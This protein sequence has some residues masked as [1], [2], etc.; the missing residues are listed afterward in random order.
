MRYDL[1]STLPERAFK[2]SLFK[3]APATL[4]GGGKGGG[5]PS[6]TQATSYQTNVPEYARP[7]VENMLNATQKQLFNTDDSG[8]TGFK[9]Y[10]P[11]SSNPSDYYAGFSPM[12]QQAQSSAANLQVPGQFGQA[13]DMATMS[14]MG[15]LG[16]AGQAGMYG[17]QGN[18][19]G[20]RAAGLSNMYGGAGA[21]AGQQAAGIS[22]MYGG[23]GAMSGQQYANQSAGAGQQGAD[24]GQQ[25]GGQSAMYGGMGAMQ[26]MQG[27][28][29]GQ[30]LGQMST[31]ANAQQ[32]Y[33]NPY[34]QNALNPQ[35]AEIQRQYDITGQGQQSAAAKSG[36]FG[37]SREALMAAENQR[38]KNMAM[39]QVIGQ[40]YNQAFT[41]AQQQMNAANQAALSG[42][43]QALQGYGMGL[44][45]VGQAG[46]L[47]MQ[48]TGQALQGYGQAG[49]QALAGY[50]MG[51]QGAGQAGQQAMQ[52]YG[53]GLQGAGQA[54]SQA[55]QGAGLGLQG[56]GA[57]QNAYNQLGAAGSNLANIGGQQLAAQQGIIGTQ[58]QQGATQQALEQSKINQ[59][60][61]DYA[62]AQQYPMMQL[63]A[64]SNMLRGLPMQ[65]TAV[66]SYQAQ[67]PVAQQAAGLL[68]AYN[69]YTG[70]KE[71]G[72]IK[73]MAKGG[74][75][76]I[77][78]YKSGVLIGL[79][80]KI[81]DIAQSDTYAQE[82]QKQLPKLMQQTTSPGIKQLIA[83]KQAEDQLGQN[84][85]GVAA[86]NTGDLGMNMAEGGI[87][88]RFAT[89]TEVK[90]PYGLTTAAAEASKGYATPEE[91][92]TTQQGLLASGLKNVQAN[93]SPEEQ[94][95]QKYVQERRAGL[96]DK[97]RR[98]EK[99]NEALAFLK[100][101]STVG[102]LGT[103]ATEGAKSYMIGQGEIQKTYDELNDNLVKQA[104]EIKKAQR[105]EAK[106]DIDKAQTHFDKAAKYKLDAIKDNATLLNTLETHKMD[107]T[108]RERVA[109]INAAVHAAPTTFLKE[110]LQRYEKELTAE[111]A[112][113]GLPPPTLYDIQTR[114]TQATK[115][116]DETIAAADRRAAG[117]KFADFLTNIASDPGI[118]V[119]YMKASK[120]DKEAESLVKAY[121]DKKRTE[122]Y[123]AYQT[124]PPTAQN[125]PAAQNNSFVM[126]G[127]KFPDQKSLDAYKAAKAK[128]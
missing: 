17:A 22:N 50:G 87:I 83:T 105:A 54:G 59:S 93:L 89:G 85:S 77:P 39:N 35:L 88:P 3:N 76:D 57:Q 128:Q 40:G 47:G 109:Q 118:S 86:G 18:M 66:Q 82:G 71:G 101:G 34:L 21:Q 70:K 121:I 63:G 42:N 49:S 55:M 53:M 127:Y 31:N 107:N 56:V 29:I 72:E 123:N 99:M 116:T 81:D 122:I 1:E 126:D 62:T 5:T 32:A 25:Y 103:A 43:A 69:A 65:S 23:L 13:T 110:Q 100:F 15:A 94:E 73:A 113:K 75:A 24:I 117:N 44:Q 84:I 9:P 79:E 125:P 4:E 6:P 14:G 112:A 78:R 120:G 11:Y 67:A 16:T 8:I 27:A 10:K 114:M 111:N 37:G 61:Q 95:Q 26:G 124:A 106:G 80:N 104:A 19:A 36:A 12:Q 102:G 33:M 98:A 115:T 96:S 45:G 48:G 20:Q 38:N 90:D 51:L 28:N 41:N 7:Y 30:S 2:K 108:S 119:A 46:Q 64:M 58:A 52:G 92:L 74:I 60:I 68:G 97:Q 91:A